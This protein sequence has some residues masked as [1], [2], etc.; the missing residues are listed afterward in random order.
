[1]GQQQL[2]LIVLGVI[3]VGIAIAVGIS[4][5]KSSAVDANRSAIASDLAN[6]ASKAQRYYRTPVELGG[7]G[8]SFANFALSPLDTANAN[9]SYR[10][11]VAN[12]TLVVIYALGKE[13]V[14]GKFVAA[15]D[16]VTPDK[17]KITHGLATGFSGGSLQGWTTQ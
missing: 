5:F 7:G 13:K 1:M 11:V 3:I 12:D 15:V 6:L 2:L 16:S 17:S 8:N 10:A 4:M 14:G 9:G